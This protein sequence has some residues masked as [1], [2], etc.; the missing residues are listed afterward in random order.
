MRKEFLSLFPTELP[1]DCI[2]YIKS[3]L[4]PSFE[5]QLFDLTNDDLKHYIDYKINF[6]KRHS[7]RSFTF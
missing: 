7:G 1:V 4:E 3:Y 5:Q 2:K 6:R